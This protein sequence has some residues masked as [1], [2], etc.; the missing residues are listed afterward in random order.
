M[1]SNPIEKYKKIHPK[2]E[3]I[4]DLSEE[5]HIISDY[6]IDSNNQNCYSIPLHD[7][8]IPSI[9]R[10][11]IVH[12]S[13]CKLIE[14]EQRNNK[15]YAYGFGWAFNLHAA[16]NKQIQEVVYKFLNSM[17][18]N[19][20]RHIRKLLKT[21]STMVLMIIARQSPWSDKITESSVISLIMFGVD[22]MLGT[23]IDFIGTIINFGGMSFGPFLLH[24]A[25]IFGKKAIQRLSKNILKNN[26]TTVLM[27]KRAVSFYY[28]RLG[29][30]ICDNNDF[31]P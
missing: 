15:E 14:E 11:I 4:A 24:N 23:C 20:A 26:T 5:R 31:L 30:A 7:I 27:C 16:G 2:I 17:F 19:E 18:V 1:V 21:T 13:N 29:F 22:D 9:D 10:G 8:V 6:F 28:N 12:A 3:L 25:Q